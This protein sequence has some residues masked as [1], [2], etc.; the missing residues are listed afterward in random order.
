M[1]FKK[2]YLL[3]AFT[4]AFVVGAF[5]NL[6]N[7]R[8]IKQLNPSNVTSN[9]RCLKYNKTIGSIDDYWYTP[10]IKNYLSGKGFTYNTTSHLDAV[11]RTPVYPLF[12]GIH[13]FLLGETDSYAVIRW[14]QLFLFALSTIFLLFAAYNFTNDIRISWLTFLLYIFYL[15]LIAFIFYTITEALYPSLLCFFLYSLSRCKKKPSRRN[16]FL[17]GILL[18]LCILT[19][20]AVIFILPAVLLLLAIYNDFN[21]KATLISWLIIMTGASVLFLPWVMRNYIVTKG[22]IVFLEKYYGGDQMDY[23]M[24]NMHL[25]YWIACW[26]NPADLSSESVSNRLIESI[27][28]TDSMQTER[29]IDS[30]IN[31]FPERAF[32]GNTHTDVR[33]TL[34]NLSLYYKAT[35]R[36]LLSKDIVGQREQVASLSFIQLKDNFQKTNKGKLYL[37]IYTPLRYLKCLIFQSN[38]SSLAFLD[39]YQH[40]ILKIFLKILLTLINIL[41]FTSIFLILH[42]YKKYKDLFWLSFIF[43]SLTYLII[44]EVNKNFESRYIFPLMPILY[45]TAAAAAVEFVDFIKRR[46]HL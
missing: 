10:Q 4:I 21:I 31:I 38:S 15:P 14:T 39:N 32:I 1:P 43:S 41:S 42:Q 34:E 5:V 11:R 40:S 25:K 36:D 6:Y 28:F 17:C 29:T 18:A 44:M 27:V 24:P 37:L 7:I 19:R 3:L 9:A 26:E 20:P 2:R 12:Y 23:G 13:Y 33:N 8:C 46:L 35:K 45:I 22:D 30:I 16:Y